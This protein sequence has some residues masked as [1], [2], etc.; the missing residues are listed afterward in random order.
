MG[1]RFESLKAIEEAARIT[2]ARG[3]PANEV[4]TL[5]DAVIACLALTDL[6]VIQEWQLP[7]SRCSGS[8]D[9]ALERY[10]YLDDEG[11]LYVQRIEGR[12]EI[13]SWAG[14]D[15]PYETA[16]LSFSPDGHWLLIHYEFT[17]GDSLNVVLEFERPD[18]LREVMRVPGSGPLFAPD[19]RSLLVVRGDDT[20]GSY[21]LVKVTWTTVCR[22]FRTHHFA[23]R[24]DGK[25]L[26]SSDESQTDVRILDAQTGRLLRS[27]PHPNSSTALAWSDDNRLLATAAYNAKIYIWSGDIDRPQAV[28]EGHRGKV[29]A[30]TFSPSGRL[31]ASTG[32]DGTTRLWDVWSGKS[33]VIGQS[34]AAIRGHGAQ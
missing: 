31:L 6:R 21:D 33:L 15:K 4:R 23:L 10:A 11:R 9:A 25:E 19:S 14:A 13:A 34:E 26:A 18:R 29:V 2:R 32:W 24:R 17:G 16:W 8:L 20:L 1:Q 30:L 7:T 5:R 22:D 12:P 27:L 28:L 3:L